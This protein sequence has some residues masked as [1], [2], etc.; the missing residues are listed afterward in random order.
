M[1]LF[2]APKQESRVE[3]NLNPFIVVM[4]RDQFRVLSELADIGHS[5]SGY[6]DMKALRKHIR[7]FNPHIAAAYEEARKRDRQRLADNIARA[8][9][10]LRDKQGQG[11]FVRDGDDTYIPGILKGRSESNKYTV[12]V[13][14]RSNIQQKVVVN[15]LPI[16]NVVAAVPDG[17][18]LVT[19]GYW[20][21]I[22][23]RPE[24][25]RRQTAVAAAEAALKL[26]RRWP[27]GWIEGERR[28]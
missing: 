28:T 18:A 22:W 20:A 17:L 26:E 15:D 25:A 13:E 3:K 1:R 19:E 11:V 21:G 4:D 16:W 27:E 23:M 12:R 8:S 10:L 5:E 7:H 6:G 14:Y 9:A 2:A 24:Y